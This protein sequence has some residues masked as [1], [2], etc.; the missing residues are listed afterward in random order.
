MTRRIDPLRIEALKLLGRVLLEKAGLRIEHRDAG[1][2]A[3]LHIVV[4]QAVRIAGVVFEHRDAI[5]VETVQAGLGADPDLALAVQD[6]ARDGL[7]RQPLFDAQVLEPQAERR[8][9]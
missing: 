7:L 2:D 6:D 4:E 1:L 9:L 3:G 5:A 8:R